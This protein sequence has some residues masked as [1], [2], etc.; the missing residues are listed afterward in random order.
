VTGPPG[1]ATDVVVTGLGVVSPIGIGRAA[2][3]EGLF[4]GR[5]GAG[6]VDF[7]DTRDW[8]SRICCRVRDFAPERWLDPKAARRMDRTGHFGVAAAH[9]ALEDAGLVPGSLPRERVAVV[10]GTCAPMEWVWVAHEACFTRGPRFVPPTTVL[11][12][13]PDAASARIAMRFGFQGPAPTLSTACA[14]GADA[15]GHALL[16][17][18]AGMCDVALAG[19]VEA[20][21]VPS[22]MIAF[23]QAR[24][25]S[26]RNDDPE[27]A[28]RPFA[29]G[30]DGFVMGEGAGLLVLE[31]RADAEARGAR[32]DAVLTGYGATTDAWHMTAPEPQGTQRERAMI[33]AV[34][35]AGLSAD[36]I[37]FVEAH[38]TGTPQNDENETRVLRR[39]FGARAG[40]VPAPALKSM[41][42]HGLGAAAGLA[43]CAAVV[44]LGAQRLHP[45]LNLAERDPE[46]DLD[47]VAGQSR[48]AALRRGLVCAFGFGGKNAALV[49]ER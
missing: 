48:P 31:R 29:Q 12:T 28:S 3:T 35:M 15:I 6:P 13:F 32:I 41:V 42:G 5:N 37:D 25:L 16:L 18:R 49:F 8:R 2:F 10:T 45:T 11:S 44:S 17:L 20:P 43:A 1:R 21:I 34:R 4:A 38:G 22:A 39:F 46:C 23:G 30:R 26:E 14:S 36:D 7:W 27:S 24:A 33:E 40:A 19:G 9:L 47:H